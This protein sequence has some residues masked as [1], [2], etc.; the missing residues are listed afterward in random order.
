LHTELLQPIQLVALLARRTHGM[1]IAVGV[2]FRPRPVHHGAW[3]PLIRP[4]TAILGWV[5]LRKQC[6]KQYCG[7]GNAVAMV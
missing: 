7:Q 6:R 3:L 2:L 4:I 1:S 5:R